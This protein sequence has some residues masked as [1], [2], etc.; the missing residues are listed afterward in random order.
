MH[1]TPGIAP[2][3]N[4]VTTRYSR[5]LDDDQAGVPFRRDYNSS[6]PG[7]NRIPSSIASSSEVSELRTE[8]HDINI[9]VPPVSSTSCEQGTIGSPVEALVPAGKD[10]SSP[11]TKFLP[12][13]WHSK[14][15]SVILGFILA[16]KAV[17]VMRFIFLTEYD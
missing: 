11:V 10:T 12:R 4:D 1:P 16:G 2:A 8:L 13:R 7:T 3:H 17:P 9:T 15:V 14:T 6:M 5:L